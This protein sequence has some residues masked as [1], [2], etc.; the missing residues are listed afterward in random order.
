MR[1]ALTLGFQT[2]RMEAG[3]RG[4]D[5]ILNT[6]QGIVVEPACQA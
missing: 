6:V 3:H 5:T 4:A 1:R 2:G